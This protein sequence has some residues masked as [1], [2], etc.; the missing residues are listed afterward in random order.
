[1]A[2]LQEQPD[3]QR[4]DRWLWHARVV[5]GR[6]DAAELVRDGHVRVDGRKVTSPGHMV[7]AGQVLTVALAHTVRL[8][9]ITGFAERRG[10]ATS[11]AELFDEIT[12]E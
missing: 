12:D 7:K 5:R 2:D 1:M 10:S 6:T 3:R 8:L 4:L 9:R 11:A